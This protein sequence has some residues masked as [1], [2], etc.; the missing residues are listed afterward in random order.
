MR[1]IQEYMIQPSLPERLRPLE[2][3]AK[4]LWWTWH[5]DAVNLWNRLDNKLWVDTNHNPVK[6]LGLISQ[7]RLDQL[8]EDDGFTTHM[9]RVIYA[10]NDYMESSF[11]FQ[12]THQTRVGDIKIAY[13]SLEFGISESLPI[14]SGGLG[15]LAGDHLKAASDLGLPLAGMGLLYQQG[16]FQQYLNIDGWQQE[17]Y[18]E[19]DFYNMPVFP[20]RDDKGNE[21]RIHI[22]YPG[23]TVTA[24][25]WRAQV[26]RTPIFLLDSNLPENHGADRNITQQLY[27]G[28]LRMRIE[29][30]IMLGMGGT[31]ALTTLGVNPTVYHMNEGHSAFLALER[32]RQL[33][34]DKGVSFDEAKE[35]VIASSVF[36]THTPVPAGNDMFQPQLIQEYFADYQ[37]N[38]GVDAKT[39]L[40]LGRQDPFNDQEPFCMTVLAIRLSAYT[41]AVAELHSETSRKMWNGIYK[42]LDVHDTPIKNVTNGVHIRSWLSEDMWGLFDR[43]LG[44]QWVSEPANDTV[45]NRV[46]DIPDAELWRTHER[47]RER[48]VGFARDRLKSQLVKRGAPAGEIRVAD[49]ALRPDALTIGFA[50]R[51]A[52]YKRAHLLFMDMN[53]LKALLCDKD[54]PVQLV[55][56]GKAHPRDNEGKTLIKNITHIIRDEELRRHVVFI[57]NYDINVARYMVQGV[58]V[59]LNTPRRPLEA[60]GTSGMK[61]SANGALN[62]SVL[63]GW[64]DEGYG[65]DTGW[66]IG[67]GKEYLD[68]NEWD[69]IESKELYDILEKEVIPLY[70][71]RG[72]DD[73]PRGWI[74]MMKSSLSKLNTF[75][76]TNRMVRNYTTNFYLP[77]AMRAKALATDGMRRAKDLS[78][79]KKTLTERWGG[80]AIEDIQTAHSE[81]LRVGQMLEVTAFVNLSGL[82]PDSLKVETYFGPLDSKGLL[83]HGKPAPMSFL[84]R[85]GDK[86]VFKGQLPLTESGRH[87]FSIR[88]TPSHPDL[89]DRPEPGYVAWSQR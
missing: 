3:L 54:R 40:A 85:D 16:Y 18:P 27:G 80:V 36:T 20:E 61:A 49:E 65:V 88:I 8:S 67:G 4:N 89:F 66:A 41:N 83:A 26:G 13:F 25:I 5:P 59:W 19:N 58:D 7:S 37:K 2:G 76:N 69:L 63:D 23:R 34:R 14:Y 10:L 87:G 28:D 9:D 84:S 70:Y 38:T 39:F 31:I 75:F 79:W 71:D 50:R 42:G 68:N 56:S 29:Q 82:E 51:F 53:R 32:I 73:M 46:L 57:E 74:K 62:L 60:S 48:L 35:M 22:P 21:I 47:R 1:K 33:M 81:D 72:R 77:C 52:T 86:A 6:I 15:I 43:Y 44:H 17:L 45:W 12:K 11:W 64:W 24:K 78:K 55:L 30:E